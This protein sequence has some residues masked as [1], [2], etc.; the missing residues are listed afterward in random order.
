LEPKT[1]RLEDDAYENFQNNV[2]NMTY[3]KGIQKQNA[4]TNALL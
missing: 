3:L 4:L 2:Q 1:G